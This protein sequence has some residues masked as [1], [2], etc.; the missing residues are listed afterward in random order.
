MVGCSKKPKF[1]PRTKIRETFIMKMIK[2][3]IL[4]II[5]VVIIG[6]VM[7]PI[8]FKDKH[9]TEGQ[10]LYT[11]F[12]SPCHGDSGRG[13][14]YNASL[15]DPRPKD[16]TDKDEP[17]L[18]ELSNA[19]I[20][21][22]IEKGGKGLDMAPLMPVFGHT[23]SP[24]E[25]WEVVAYVRTL[26]KYKGEKVKFTP[27]IETARPRPSMIQPAEFEELIK[28]K[29]KEPG[30]EKQL[31]ELGK[32]LFDDHGCGACHQIADQG[33]KLGPVLDRVGFM[34]QP[35]FIY[36]WIENPQ[37]FKPNTRMPNLGLSKDDALAVTLYLSTLRG[38]AHPQ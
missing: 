3:L 28:S 5:A 22:V 25:I 10:R 6:A 37:A 33:G 1:Q 35:Q 18:G 8:I 34:L 2:R 30:K 26:H 20:Y 13:D 14:G 9:V 4:P 7:V 15:L 32:Q 16:L 38:E 12:C 36:R 17:Y 21:E 19:E 11:K 31:V 27:E 29:T 23:L 24:L